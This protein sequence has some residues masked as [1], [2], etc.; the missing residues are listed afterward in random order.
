[1]SRL[2]RTG[3]ELE[4]RVVHPTPIARAGVLAVEE[5][6]IDLFGRTP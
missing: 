2:F 4:L 6:I 1:M 3:N 5:I